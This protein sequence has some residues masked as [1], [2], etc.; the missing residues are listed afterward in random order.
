VPESVGKDSGAAG[1]YGDGGRPPEPTPQELAEK[2]AG[3]DRFL[4]PVVASSNPEEVGK[5]PP[6]LEEAPLTPEE[7]ETLDRLAELLD[8]LALQGHLEQEGRSEDSLRVRDLIAEGMR[9][10]TPEQRQILRR[11][12]LPELAEPGDESEASEA[13][14]RVLTLLSDRIAPEAS[15]EDACFDYMRR[16]PER[17]EQRPDGSLVMGP[18]EHAAWLRER[19]EE[20]ERRLA[21]AKLRRALARRVEVAQQARRRAVRDPAHR[22]PRQPRRAGA[23]TT[24]GLDPPPEDEP[25]P[26]NLTT[27]VCPPARR[28]R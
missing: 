3:L 11:T 16:H 27:A 28:G 1:H 20:W 24:S 13:S 23:R 21:F 14:I 8:L 2:L 5:P 10:L 7:H 22:S 6:A 17:M 26:H 15:A 12:D 9:A 25:P 4:A 18:A 19:D